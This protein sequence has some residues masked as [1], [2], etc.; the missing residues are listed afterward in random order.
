MKGWKASR[1]MKDTAHER[2]D[3]EQ[4]RKDSELDRQGSEQLTQDIKP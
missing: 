2:L 1:K 4:E 3:S